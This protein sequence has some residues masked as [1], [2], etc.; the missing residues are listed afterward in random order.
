MIPLRLT[1]R[2]IPFVVDSEMFFKE[3]IMCALT[4]ML[5]VGLGTVLAVALSVLP[6]VS[7]QSLGSDTDP[8]TS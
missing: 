4:S 1:E 5:T 8:P 6:L 2:P 7:N 3:A